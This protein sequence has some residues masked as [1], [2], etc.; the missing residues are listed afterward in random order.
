M[1]GNILCVAAV[2]LGIDARWQKLPDGGLEYQ[3]QIEP[4]VVKNVDSS[5]VLIQSD[6]PPE[7]R[8]IRSFRITVGK[9]QLP[10]ESLP[11][12]EVEPSKQGNATANKP[13]ADPFMPP[14]STPTVGLGPNWLAPM[15]RPGSPAADAGQS[16]PGAA[17][18]LPLAASPGQ[19]PASPETPAIPRTLLPDPSG[20]RSTC[21]RPSISRRPSRCRRPARSRV[22][23]RRPHR[24]RPRPGWP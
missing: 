18:A 1:C 6:V 21:S 7:A 20:R 13:A 24:S 19:E 12:A 3:I 23:A 15:D 11:P 9:A 17:A 8:D 4:D 10:Q 16:L 22:P 14:A 2:L 5:G